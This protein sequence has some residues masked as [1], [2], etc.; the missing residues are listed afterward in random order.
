MYTVGVGNIYLN[1]LLYI[2]SDPDVDHVFLLRSYRDADTFVD[3]LGAS[4]CESKKE[5]SVVCAALRLCVL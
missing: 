1:E 4:L 2:A 3:F 5:P